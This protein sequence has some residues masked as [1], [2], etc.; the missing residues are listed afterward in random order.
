MRFRTWQAFFCNG[1]EGV[2]SSGP[3]SS[4]QR[5]RAAAA[6]ALIAC[7]QVTGLTAQAPQ[8]CLEALPAGRLPADVRLEPLRTLDGY[9]PMELP[10]SAEA[11]SERA[12]RLRR[13]VLVS[14]GLWPLPARSPLQAVIHGKVSRD[15]YTVEKVYFQS[16]PGHFVTGN[17]YRP[18]HG[19]TRLPAVL[20]PHGH[21]GSEETR[22]L[23]GRFHDHGRQGVL[24]QIA[25][26][27]ERFEVGGR[28]PLQARAVQLARMG[29]VVFQYDM[30]GY[31]DS[32]Q[33]AH[34]G[35]G[36]REHMNTG[37]R[38]G[39]ASPQ[40]E[41]WL[42]SLMGLQTWNSMRALDFLLS[43]P[44]VDP[45][46]V[47]VEGHSGGG[48]QTFMLT[49]IDE[50]PAA[51]FVGVM[52]STAMQG[53]CI[54]EN[55]PYLRVGAGNVDLAALTAPRPL[56]MTGAN[57]WTLQLG[58]KGYPELQ[59]LY[60]MLGWPDRVH[61]EVFPQFG[62][63]YNSVSRTVM[64]NWLNR[65]LQLG[66]SEPVIERDYLPLSLE[67]MSVW[68]AKHPPPSGVQ[69]GDEHERALLEVWKRDSERQLAAL[70]PKDAPSLAEYR[71]VVGGAF[72]V[73]LGRRLEELEP[74][75]YQPVQREEGS[76]CAFEVGLLRNAAKREELPI[77]L[78][79]PPGGRDGR[80]LIWIDPR[81]KRG[82]LKPDGQPRDAVASALEAG[83]T[84]VGVDLFEQGEFLRPGETL[85]SARLAV[86]GDGSQPWHR[87]SAFTFG[88]NYSLF[89]RRTH[90]IL[91]VIGALKDPPFSATSISLAGFGPTAGPLAAAALA[92]SSGVIDRAAI[93][94]GGFRFS[95]LDRID[96][97]MFL[98][99]AVK[100]G[101]LPALLS[102]S[103]ARELWLA[104]EGTEAP[105]A[106]KAVVASSR[107]AISLTLGV[108]QS[109]EEAVGWLARE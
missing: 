56:G 2:P 66:F 17:L 24:E 8:A 98:P 16:F 20:S 13:Q 80:F 30:V 4:V 73:I 7:L 74:A 86:R 82:L 59:K 1:V 26:G 51:A 11:W 109:E 49:A 41:L 25:S 32:L 6:L 63:N 39:L 54:C 96:D 9:F 90:D 64:Y 94:T 18:R 60:A 21:T 42:Q 108:D 72:D 61:A 47:A 35:L 55:A 79:R 69:V 52:V 14:L 22:R 89:S 19:G 36:V 100:Y 29:A 99:G 95:Q 46:R 43:L 103:A 31:S 53:G 105:P 62:H 10:Q 91:S 92:Q 88:Y 50:R 15:D 33:L 57:D 87:A 34:K 3:T 84:V 78:L 81:G 58:E 104:G 76:T 45:D 67:E 97:P 71:R 70:T 27:A 38:W 44:E 37:T 48:T 107:G 5:P 75:Q 93:D 77:L 40:A 28:H 101:G 106:L 12:Q 85:Q 102:A 65:H 23:N 68:N 83:L